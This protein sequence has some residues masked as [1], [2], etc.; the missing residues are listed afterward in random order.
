MVLPP[1][2]P[3]DVVIVRAVRTPL[4]R[5]S[6]GALADV[7]AATMWETVVKAVHGGVDVQDM[8]VG[9]VLLGSNGFAAIRM[10][11][12]VAGVPADKCSLQLVNRQCA[13][14]LEAI[15]ILAEK[16]RSKQVQVGIAGGVESMS[17]TPMNTIKPP[18]VDYE[19]YKLHPQAM[20]CLLPMGLTSENVAKK[21]QLERHQLDQFAV[22]SHQKASQ[23]NF[24]PEIVPVRHP[25]G[26]MVSKDDGIRPQTTIETLSRLRPAFIPRGS[27]TAGNASQTTD[28]AAAVLLMTRAEAQQRGLPIL[29]RWVH[30]VTAAVPPHLMGMGPVEAIPKLLQ[31]CQLD[32]SDIDVWELN[33]AFATQASTCMKL[34]KLP[35]AKVNPNGGAIAM[36]HPLGCTG[37]RMITTLIY[38]LH[39]RKQHRGVVS[40][41]VGTGM[42]AAALIEVEDESLAQ[43]SLLQQSNL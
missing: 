3:D 14:G 6:K 43:S 32:V 4:C 2:S 13:S 41:C 12:V 38:E 29:A 37:T 7:P 15:A 28:G 39:R 1:P 27:T 35:P 40:M 11:H 17:A 9:N 24:T 16:I 8:V 22:E 10:A 20:D 36:G 42:G 25:K 18:T 5:S 26:H 34:L 19:R 23:A 30:Y 21:H 31:H 33:E